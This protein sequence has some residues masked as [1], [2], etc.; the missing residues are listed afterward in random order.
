MKRL[1]FGNIFVIRFRINKCRKFFS[2]CSIKIK[3][4]VIENREL[5][6]RK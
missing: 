5:S 4:D 3:F 6:F 2:I 1:C